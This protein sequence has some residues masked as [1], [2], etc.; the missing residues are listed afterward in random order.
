MT[1][2]RV[3]EEVGQERQNA[4]A[5]LAQLQEEA[6]RIGA[7]LVAAQAAEALDLEQAV[8]EGKGPKGSKKV[9]SLRQRAEEIRQ[10]IPAI[11][12]LLVRL[13]LEHLRAQIPALEAT[14]TESSAALEEAEEAFQAARQRRT[15][16]ANQTHWAYQELDEARRSLRAAEKR[17][18]SQDPRFAEQQAEELAQ[19]RQQAEDMSAA[20]HEQARENAF[21]AAGIYEYDGDPPQELADMMRS[22]R[23]KITVRGGG[24]G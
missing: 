13:E 2:P 1:E 3:L 8:R 24:S 4:T 12:T 9:A 15:A 10:Q 14:Q 11:N 20:W 5:A 6:A 17:L 16:A 7:D 23:G 22:G 18:A 19:R 21:A